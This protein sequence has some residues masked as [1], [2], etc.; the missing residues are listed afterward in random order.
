MGSLELADARAA[1]FPLKEPEGYQEPNLRAVALAQENPGRL[2]AFVRID[3][4]DRPLALVREALAAGA[5]GLKLHPDGEQFD[6]A[7][8]RL[9]E[10]YGVAHEESLPIII[11]ARPEIE[12]VGRTSGRS[13]SRRGWR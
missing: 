9:D 6:I 1:V 5:R 8:P 3:P 2:V 7:D 12:G 10:V 11:H 13:A 4:S